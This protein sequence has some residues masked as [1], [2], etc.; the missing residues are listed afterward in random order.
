MKRH[1]LLTALLLSVFAVSAAAQNKITDLGT[2]SAAELDSRVEKSLPGFEFPKARHAA[3]LKK[4]SYTTTDAKGK[5]EQVSGL[6]I[7]P[8]GGA[9]KGLVV[10]MHGTT[11]DYK[12]APSRVT[13][14]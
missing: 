10:Y 1:F 12:N 7:L 9:P 13:T 6:L 5:R 3:D 8:K 4:V 2:Y 11:W 14:N